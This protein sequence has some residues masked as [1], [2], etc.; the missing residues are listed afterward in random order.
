MSS[1]RSLFA[2]PAMTVLAGLF[3]AGAHTAV[4]Q[5]LC[6]HNDNPVAKIGP[7]TG[8]AGTPITVT[9]VRTT[10]PSPPRSLV[11]KRMVAN[12]TPANV[13]ARVSGGAVAAPAQLCIN[14]PGR[15]EVWLIDGNGRS[16][17]KI[18]AFWP[19]CG[20][21][22]SAAGGGGTGVG[23]SGG[24]GGGAG[25]GGGSGGGG[26]GGAAVSNKIDRCLVGAWE[27]TDSVSGIMR[28]GKGMK[29]TFKADR[30]FIADYTAM[31][32][33]T[34]TGLSYGFAGTAQGKTSTLDGQAASTVS[35]NRATLDIRVGN[36][37]S[38]PKPSKGPA[39]G[40]NKNDNKYTCD[41]RWLSFV[42]EDFTGKPWFSVRMKRVGAK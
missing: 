11:F 22:T 42:Q 21:G 39:L 1:R 13:T 34:I 31:Q 5:R 32:P 7:C 36:E 37:P 33:L 35:D 14:G 17:G 40:M 38:R 19:E 15:W 18:G 10:V 26:G 4:G 24:T 29:L 28:G 30:S 9:M 23:S 16:Q 20:G 41:T 6:E 27:V 12:A 2:F 8:P 25:G 3:L